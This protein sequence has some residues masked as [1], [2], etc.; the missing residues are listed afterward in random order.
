MHLDANELTPL[1]NGQL[2]KGRRERLYLS[3]LSCVFKYIRGVFKVLGGLMFVR[4]WC[5]L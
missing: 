1:V 2:L 4:S 3:R 5:D